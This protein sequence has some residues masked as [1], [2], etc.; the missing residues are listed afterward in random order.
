MRQQLDLRGFDKTPRRAFASRD[1]MPVSQAK[2]E[3]VSRGRLPPHTS[4]PTASDPSARQP[5]G[6]YI[7][8]P[9]ARRRRADRA[10]A[11][12]IR[13]ADRSG[14]SRRFPGERRVLSFFWNIEPQYA[15]LAALI[16]RIGHHRIRG[17]IAV[18]RGACVDLATY[19]FIGPQQTR[20]RRHVL[21]MRAAYRL[22]WPA[23]PLDIGI[24]GPIRGRRRAVTRW[25]R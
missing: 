4:S 25:R 23:S 9:P 24:F 3:A 22:S 16:A 11:S 12:N 13:A 19:E 6:L 1:G 8:F 21:L 20:T 15:F 5:T 18:A 2:S 14:L 10:T 7:S 17:R